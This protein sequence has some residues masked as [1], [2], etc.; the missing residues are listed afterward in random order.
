MPENSRNF[1]IALRSN[2]EDLF[3]TTLLSLQKS[4]GVT[5]FTSLSSCYI[6]SSILL[7][8]DIKR[9]ARQLQGNR[10]ESVAAQEGYG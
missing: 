6:F 3:F 4:H 2:H 8:E 1:L 5:L 10:G 7:R 9:M